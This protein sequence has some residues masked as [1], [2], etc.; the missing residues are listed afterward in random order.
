MSGSPRRMRGPASEELVPAKRLEVGVIGLR[1]L[2]VGFGVLENLTVARAPGSTPDYTVPLGF[3]LVAILAIANL[4]IS[5][6]TERADRPSAVRRIGAAAFAI[7]IAVITGLVW[8]YTTPRN[9][10]WVIAYVLP[11]EGALRFGL[12]GALLPIAIAVAT[13]P[14]REFALSARYDVV[15]Q[16][17]AIVF[18]VGVDTVV[19][20]V[21]GLMARSLRREAEG[22]RD[23]A[24]LA[25]EAAVRL[26][27]LDQMKSDFVA[28]T[29][30]ELRT[31]LAAIRGF[32]NTILRRIDQ[33]SADEVREFLAIVDQQT[34]RLIRLVEDLLVVSKIEAGKLGFDPQT[35]EPVHFLAHVVRGLAEGAARVRVETPDALP[36]FVA[37]ANR[38]GQVLVNLLQNAL[39][40]SSPGLPVRLIA[41]IETSDDGELL[42]FDVIDRGVGIAREESQAIFERFHQT[43]AASTRQAEG[44]GLGLYITK[45][46]VE[47]MEGSISVESEVGRGST[48]TVRLPLRRSPAPARPS[49]AAPVG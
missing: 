16:P 14:M 39:K 40:F 35:I 22:A 21:A 1:W 10:L 12:V 30:H 5:V 44:T 15:A 25:E 28:I 42:R 36:T 11:L 32:V 45:K 9:S 8:T 18:R 47:A 3:G 2:A 29:S 34:D 27:E 20:V 7:D 19:A 23:R 26:Q 6:L 13:E 46:L 41:G 31:P 37:D 17:W 43:E 4:A 49:E 38:L 24:W 33:L 48:F